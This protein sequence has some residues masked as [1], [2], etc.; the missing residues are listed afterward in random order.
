MNSVG[1]V[2]IPSKSRK[3]SWSSL[4]TSA[5]TRAKSPRKRPTVVKPIQRTGNRRSVSSTTPCPAGGRLPISW[6]TLDDQ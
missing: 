4:W 6:R 2:L 5:R 1:Q 3:G